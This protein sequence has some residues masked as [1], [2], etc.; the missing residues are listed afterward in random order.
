MLAQLTVEGF[1][2]G[3]QEVIACRTTFKLHQHRSGTLLACG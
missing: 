2:S 3:D 1:V